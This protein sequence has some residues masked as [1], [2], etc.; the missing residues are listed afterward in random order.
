MRSAISARTAAG[1]RSPASIAVAAGLQR[2]VQDR[3]GGPLL[4]REV[5]VAARQGQAVGLADR[6]AADHL[7]RDRQ[8]AHH[9][10]DDRE[11]LEVLLAEV[12]PARARRW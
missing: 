7:D 1:S 11:L 9:P 4:G 2:R 8:V 6:R 3:G 10:A 5:D 12:G